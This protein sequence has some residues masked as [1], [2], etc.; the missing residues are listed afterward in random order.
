MA[1][2]SDNASELALLARIHWEISPDM[3]LVFIGDDIL[4]CN[5]AGAGILEAESTHD[6]LQRKLLRIIDPEYRNDYSDLIRDGYKLGDNDLLKEELFV[7][8]KFHRVWLET[9][10]VFLEFNGKKAWLV[11]GRKIQKWKEL[12][13]VCREQREEI[14]A[15]LLDKLTKKEKQILELYGLG[16][17]RVAI[18]RELEIEEGTVDRHTTNIKRKLK[19]K[20]GRDLLNFAMDLQKPE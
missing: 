11:Y 18:A 4:Y 2:K 3:I 16:K 13:E 19:K 9:K 12:E 5:D 20:R 7:T 14:N 15:M 8:L 6:V 10:K 17:N 1:V